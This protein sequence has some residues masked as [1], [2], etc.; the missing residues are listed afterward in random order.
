MHA[1]RISETGDPQ[2]MA[3]EE[4]D[5]PTAAADG[6]VVT[7][8]AAGVNYID[9]YHR[10]GLYEMPLPFTPGLEG[11]GTITAAGGDVSQWNVGD[12]V[13]WTGAIGSYAEQ[14]AMPAAS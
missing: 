2:V 12:K 11:S 8:G 3:L 14:V 4:V 10:S 13:A 6:I 7:V 1:I 5:E 9:T